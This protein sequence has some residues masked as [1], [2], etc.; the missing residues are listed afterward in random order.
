VNVVAQHSFAGLHISR[1]KAFDRFA[2][3]FFAK[4]GITPRPRLN[5]LFEIPRQSHLSNLL[6]LSSFVVL[7]AALSVRD[8]FLLPFLGSTAKQQ[9]H[10]LAVPAEIHS[11]TGTEIDLVF[12]NAAAYALY[13]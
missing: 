10:P 9:N 6:F 8:V 2:Q 4:C 7:P 12:M 3:Q 11:I 13:A 5:R 1:N